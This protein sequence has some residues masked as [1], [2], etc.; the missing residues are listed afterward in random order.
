[1]KADLKNVRT[2][3]SS[4]IVE[5][6]KIYSIFLFLW[7]FIFVYIYILDLELLSIFSNSWVLEVEQD[8]CEYW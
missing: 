1:M 5:A 8:S 3:L 2:E 6:E 4:I 7:D